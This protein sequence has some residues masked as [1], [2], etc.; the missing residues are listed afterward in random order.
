MFKYLLFIQ[1]CMISDDKSGL[2]ILFEDH[3]MSIIHITPSQG[4]MDGL[5]N[6]IC[7][8]A[9]SPGKLRP[10]DVSVQIQKY[11]LLEKMDLFERRGVEPN[12]TYH[13]TP[14]GEKI[15]DSLE[16]DGVYQRRVAVPI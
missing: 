4:L 5:Y 16:E 9:D 1:I 6:A 7:C 13:L 11:I 8:V 12:D 10:C 14:K 2:E 3:V 15:H